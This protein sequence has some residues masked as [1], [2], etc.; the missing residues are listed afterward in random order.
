MDKTQMDTPNSSPR[1]TTHFQ[2][3]VF[4]KGLIPEGIDPRHVEG[5]IRLE[6]A[7]LGHLSWQT[8][9]REVKIALACIKEG[10]VADAELCAKSWG[11]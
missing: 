11:L 7:T 8:I 2:K 1:F 10:G 3:Q 5:Y 6:Y 9:R 4:E